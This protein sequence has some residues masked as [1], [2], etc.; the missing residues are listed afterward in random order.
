MAVWI[1]SEI[2]IAVISGVFP[3]V[4]GVASPSINA[5]ATALPITFL[6]LFETPL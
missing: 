3:K 4:S 2:D 6:L 5:F 1:N